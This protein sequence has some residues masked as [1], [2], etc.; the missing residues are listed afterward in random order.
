MWGSLAHALGNAKRATVSFDAYHSRSSKVRVLMKQRG[1]DRKVLLV[2]VKLKK[3]FTRYQVSTGMCE[4][5]CKKIRPDVR[6]DLIFQV[7]SSPG[8]F[9]IRNIDVEV[10]H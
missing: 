5:G 3:K 6:Y 1:Y 10:D 9:K 4:S 2:D 7:G 8:L